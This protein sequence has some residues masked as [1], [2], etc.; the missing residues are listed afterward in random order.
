MHEI[1]VLLSCSQLLR[2]GNGLVLRVR[3][4]SL[5]CD[6]IDLVVRAIDPI[7]GSGGERMSEA[8]V[9]RHFPPIEANGWARNSLSWRKQLKEEVPWVYAT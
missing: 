2:L 9:M 1:V 3:V 4:S 5:G 8:V 6:A 7:A